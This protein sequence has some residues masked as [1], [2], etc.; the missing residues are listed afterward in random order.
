MR[1][2][3]VGQ[4]SV[5]EQLQDL[6][7]EWRPDVLQVEHHVMMQFANRWPDRKV[8][9]A[10]I[11]Y[12]PGVV[13]AADAVSAAAGLGR[14]VAVLDAHAWGEYETRAVGIAE[15]VIVFT[16]RDAAT[17]HRLVPAARIEVLPLTIDVPA[18]RPIAEPT[19]PPFI[20]F[21]G[22]YTHPPNVDAAVRLATR[23]YP[24]LKRRHPAL[25]LLLVGPGGG[26]TLLNLASEG[27]EVLGRVADVGQYLL[28]ATAVVIPIRQGGG[29]R[30]K[31]MEALASGTAIVASALAIEGLGVVPG[32]DLLVA[33]SD[34]EFVA[35]VGQ[36]L[37]DPNRRAELAAGAY[38]WAKSH[39]DW[40]DRM[41][42]LEA[43]YSSLVASGVDSA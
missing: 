13:S 33:E 8:P 24:V 40:D 42:R 4:A 28:T 2:V 32:R 7:S 14:I 35:G 21:V 19:N 31:V 10:F 37:L 41:R 17:L 23:I 3:D 1:V 26:R 22:N 16:S 43:L 25:R 20:L 36:L 6:V 18:R 15:L 5:G 27:V 38:Q 29:M 30:L 12:E 9:I 34:T 39:L 11:E